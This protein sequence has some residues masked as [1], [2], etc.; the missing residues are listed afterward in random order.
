L[1][2]RG[3]VFLDQTIYVMDYTAKIYGSNLNDATIFDAL[4]FIVASDLPG[5]GKAIARHESFVVA[6][7]ENSVEFFY[8]AANPT[9]SPLSALP[10]STIHWGCVDGGSVQDIEGKLFWVARSKQA[11]AFVAMLD[12]RQHSRISTEGVE[13]LLDDFQNP[14]DSFAFKDMGHLFYGFTSQGSNITLVYDLMQKIWYVWTDAKGNFWPWRSFVT[15]TTWTVSV[16]STD[17]SLAAN[18]Y[19][20][21]EEFAT[22]LGVAIPVDI[23][24]GNYDSGSRRRDVLQ[25]MD[26]IVDQQPGKLKVRYTEDDYK[27]WSNFREVDLNQKRP[28]LINCGSFRRRA[29]NFRWQAGLPLR[30]EAVELTV[31]PGVA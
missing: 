8:D 11:S 21:D 15:S 7:K 24:T 23:Y 20:I 31:I 2:A 17:D 1:M 13:R 27:T 26:F 19:Q 25:R 29:W 12:H 4:N 16:Q 10:N 18:T 28:T 14:I 5:A 30:V 3:M 9:G 22:D 6:L